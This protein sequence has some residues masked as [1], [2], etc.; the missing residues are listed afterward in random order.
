MNEVAYLN[1]EKERRRRTTNGGE[2]LSLNGVRG[3]LQKRLP[4]KKKSRERE[5]TLERQTL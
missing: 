3:D 2:D 1:R 4:Q 5:K